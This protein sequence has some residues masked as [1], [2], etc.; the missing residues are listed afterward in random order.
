M[1]RFLISLAVLLVITGVIAGCDALRGGADGG[2]GFSHKKHVTDEGIDCATCH[3][4]TSSGAPGMPELKTCM[5]CHEATDKEKS[6]KERVANRFFKDGKPV[7]ANHVQLPEETIFA[8]KNHVDRKTDCGV[9]HDGI[10]ENVRT[11]AALAPTMATCVACHTKEKDNCAYCHREVR[12]DRKPKSHEA[13]WS[14]AHGVTARQEATSWSNNSCAACHEESAC[15]ECHQ[16]RKPKD[17]NASW[18]HEIH[19]VMA[20][21]DRSR[22]ATCHQTDYCQRCHEETAPRSHRGTW[23]APLDGHCTNCHVTSTAYENGC[24][25]CHK[26]IVHEEAPRRPAYGFHRP[27]D[28]C[29]GCHTP[30]KHPNNGD[31]C[32]A[33]H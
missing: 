19:G 12:K 30:L 4:A 10:K 5:E 22:C 23:G 1:K 29:V 8:H 25:V 14:Q 28:N 3:A 16:N 15:M 26:P 20:G 11:G 33:C 32:T 13:N 7:W 9:C 17:H 21:V 2:S 24:G 18:R 27:T 31:A 6:E